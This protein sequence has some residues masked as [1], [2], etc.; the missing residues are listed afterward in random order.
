MTAQLD[1]GPR[2]AG[3][4]ESEGHRQPTDSL[5]VAEPGEARSRPML[6]LERTMY[7]DG[8][9]PFASL[10]TVRLRGEMSEP[11]LRLALAQM[12]ARHP[13]LRCVV[14]ESENGPRFVLR[15]QP[16][17]VPLR[18]VERN[19]GSVWENEARREWVTP[20]GLTR[21]PLVRAV[22][23]RGNG[24]HELMLVAHHSI[25]DG[26]SGMTILRDCFAAYDDPQP[27]ADAYDSLGAI[28]DLV[29]EEL[30]RERNFHRRVRRRSALLRLALLLKTR[31]RPGRH[32][33]LD[34][35]RMYFHRWQLDPIEAG[36]LVDRCREENVTV[37][38]AAGVAFLQAFREI[39][40]PG[41]LKHAYTM[42][43]ARRFLP[44]MHGEAL[45][46]IAPG[47]EMLIQK[48]LAPEKTSVSAFWERARATREDL[49]RRIER[50]GQQIYEFL[51]A[52]ETLH[53]RYPR[54]VA[55]TEVAPEVRHV[56]F[57]NLGRL[58]LPQQ[59]R[60]FQIEQVHSPLVMVSPSP[61]NT[62]VL[63][64]F[65]GAME[66]AI[67]SDELALPQEQARAIAGRT[68]DLLRWSAGIAVQE[69][70]RTHDASRAPGVAAI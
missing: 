21:S 6:L 2:T 1:V 41:A 28:E 52:L 66:F 58:D 27:E 43:N 23:L 53:D 13:L 10:F 61:A 45:F 47:V 63:S 67:I 38:A 36:N 40:G 69:E 8:L 37:L 64:S 54:L 20:F 34:A 62:V 14:E 48:L 33:S 46:G 68:M 55:D 42:V 22:W 12:Q 49:T 9:A 18:I 7:R 51:A 29:P 15:R 31:H 30:L 5:D 39:R 11:R 26:P 16:A 56:T 35:D 44:R 57:S 59:Y 65:E 50:L 4:T 17:P 19:T 70:C 24:V 60:S 32:R 3:T 25:C